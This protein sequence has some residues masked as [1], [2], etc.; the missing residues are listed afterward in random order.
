MKLEIINVE[1]GVA[2]IRNMIE[3]SFYDYQQINQ[4]WTWND[5]IAVFYFTDRDWIVLNRDNELYTDL[6]EIVLFYLS[7][8]GCEREKARREAKQHQ[9]QGLDLVKLL[10]LLDN[11]T[12]IRSVTRHL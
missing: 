5:K 6:K 7:I 3:F 10:D 11:V 12:L 4:D 2:S 1:L 9:K 8:P